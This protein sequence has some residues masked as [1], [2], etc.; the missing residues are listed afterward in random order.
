MRGRLNKEVDYNGDNM[1]K[2]ITICTLA[3]CT[4]TLHTAIAKDGKKWGPTGIVDVPY[5]FGNA[6]PNG[7]DEISFPIKIDEA[8]ERRTFYYAMQYRFVGGDGAYTGLQA[9]DPGKAL[10]IFSVWGK[11]TKPVASNCKGGA[12]GEKGMSCSKMIDFDFG[13]K[14]EITVKR[15]K[16]DP[17]IWRGTI[18]NVTKKGPSSEIGAWKLPNSY[19]GIEV[20]SGG[21]VEYFPQISSCN[22]IPYTRGFFGL[23]TARSGNVSATATISRPKTYGKCASVSFSTDQTNDGWHV[24]VGNKKQTRDTTVPDDAGTVDGDDMVHDLPN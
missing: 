23:P 7:F 8:P 5:D 18:R 11:G 9:R 22:D 24:K 2:I 4:L 14:Y 6:P 16:K 17:Q 10:A 19:K 3:I 12:D 20:R 21:F 1:K 15:D 13:S